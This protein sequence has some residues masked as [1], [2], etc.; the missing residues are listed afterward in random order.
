MTKLMEDKKLKAT[1]HFPVEQFGYAEVEMEVKS[2]QEAIDA[3]RAVKE[4]ELPVEG[5]NGASGGIPELE[6]NKV[7]DKYLATKTMTS[8]EYESLNQ[9]QKDII[10]CL[11]RSFKRTNK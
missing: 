9:R 11:K 4:G 3:Y 6:F 7:L 10:Q 8:D 1:L 2:P 5:Q